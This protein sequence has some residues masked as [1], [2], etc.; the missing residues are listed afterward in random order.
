[1]PSVMLMGNEY[2]LLEALVD[3]R[4]NASALCV[5]D[6]KVVMKEQETL[7]SW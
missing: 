4:K 3:H 7:R 6:Q 1:M 2:L 5:K